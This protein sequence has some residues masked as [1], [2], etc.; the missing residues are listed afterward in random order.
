MNQASTYVLK[1]DSAAGVDT[2]LMFPGFQSESIEIDS[3]SSGPHPNIAETHYFVDNGGMSKDFNI[4]FFGPDFMLVDRGLD[5]DLTGHIT[6]IKLDVGSLGNQDRTLLAHMNIFPDATLNGAVPLDSLIDLTPQSLTT[7]TSQLAPAI[8]RAY[9]NLGNDYLIG[10]SRNDYFDGSFGA[11]KME[12]LGG[13]DIYVVDNSR[14]KVIEKL[15][16]GTDSVQAS[17]SFSLDGQQIENLTLTGSG[18]IAGSGNALANTI[19][20][21][22]A[23]NQI[24]GGFGRD[25]LTGGGGADTFVYRSL[26]ESKVAGTGRDTI[27]DFHHSQHDR[28]DLHTIDANAKVHGNQA[29]H[30]IGNHAFG[31]EAGELQVKAT[32]GGH[33]LVSADVNGD[34]R[35]DFAILLQGH[36][37]VHAGDFLL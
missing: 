24:F 11:D 6:E 29:F 16:G 25:T 15:G 9:G 2:R 21:N 33:T 32:A 7:S 4:T 28:I 22:G 14:D 26:A 5:S 1:V 31:H 8:F 13:N 34:A 10:T 12:G 20:G 19:V 37:G 3:V 36:V 27:T 17:P 23:G 35:A 18:S 30:F